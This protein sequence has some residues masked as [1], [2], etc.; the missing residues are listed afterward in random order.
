M[1]TEVETVSKFTWKRIGKTIIELCEGLTGYALEVNTTQVMFFPL[2]DR[3]KA[4]K[5]YYRL[6]YALS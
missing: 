3:D 2:E 5:A 1:T 4:W 6:I